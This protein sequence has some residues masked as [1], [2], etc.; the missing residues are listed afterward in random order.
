MLNFWANMLK[1]RRQAEGA[2]VWPVFHIVSH[3]FGGYCAANLAS[4][5]VTGKERVYYGRV[6]AS[7]KFSTSGKIKNGFG[8]R[9]SGGSA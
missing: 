2:A 9:V 8:Y 6:A 1:G 7:F 4:V 3:K 5:K